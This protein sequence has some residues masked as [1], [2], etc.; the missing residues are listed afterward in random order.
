VRP[1][2]S[3]F[4]SHAQ[5]IFFIPGGLREENVLGIELPTTQCFKWDSH[6][7]QVAVPAERSNVNATTEGGRLILVKH[8]CRHQPESAAK[9]T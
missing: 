8:D 6:E 4:P 3:T 1:E 9:E 5:V 2:D 7:I